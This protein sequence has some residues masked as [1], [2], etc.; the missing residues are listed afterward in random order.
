MKK[1]SNNQ[2]LNMEKG[3][4]KRINELPHIKL[5]NKKPGYHISKINKGTLGD[6]SKIQEELDE[7]KD[8]ENQQCKIM[9]ALEL[10][11]MIGAIESYS[12]KHLGLTLN[13]L[14]KMNTI[15][16]RA[17]KNGRRK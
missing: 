16:Q 9:V 13:D 3:A 8:A 17:F 11:D 12:N 15:T 7:A 10:S 1:Y 14:L 2:I 6:L 4:L 5:K